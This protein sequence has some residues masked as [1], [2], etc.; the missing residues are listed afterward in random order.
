MFSR[1]KILGAKVMPA[2]H[3][4]QTLKEAVDSAFPAYLSDLENSIY[5]AIGSVVRHHQF[6]EVKLHLSSP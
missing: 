6:A 1:M 3:G 4:A 2:I 5:N